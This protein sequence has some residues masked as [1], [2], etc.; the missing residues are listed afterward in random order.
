M[1]VSSLVA[2]AAPADAAVPAN[3]L[4][5]N[6]TP[7]GPGFEE[8]VDATDATHDADDLA[9]EEACRGEPNPFPHLL[10]FAD[11]IWYS[12]SAEDSGTNSVDTTGEFSGPISFV[13]IQTPDGFECVAF[14]GGEVVFEAIAG[15]TYTVAVIDFDPTGFPLSVKFNAAVP[16]SLVV[17]V[18]DRGGYYID[19]PAEITGTYTCNS[20]LSSLQLNVLVLQRVGKREIAGFE[21][22]SERDDPIC[23]ESP[24]PWVA[25]VHPVNGWYR[26]GQAEVTVDINDCSPRNCNEDPVGTK[27]VQLSRLGT[28]GPTPPELEIDDEPVLPPIN[29]PMTNDTR[30]T[31]YALTASQPVIVDTR[32]ATTASE[33]DALEDECIY[34]IGGPPDPP[35]PYL[36]K[37][38]WFTFTAPRDETIWWVNTI[39]SDYL[40]FLVSRPLPGSVAPELEHASCGVLEGPLIAPTGVPVTIMVT[41]YFGP[42]DGDGGELQIVVQD[43][44]PQAFGTKVS[45]DPVA[46]FDK[47][48]V[49]TVTGTYTC[50]EPFP[51]AVTRIT[52]V[53]Q[54]HQN[55]GRFREGM[56][57]QIF[58][59][60]VDCDGTVGTWSIE[61]D[62]RPF[63]IVYRGGPAYVFVHAITRAP[64]MAAEGN[65]A[66]AFVQLKGGP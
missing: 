60:D 12:F 16:F 44:P 49:A 50:F 55:I 52:L 45:I 26:G 13:A 20:P 32:A 7:V 43:H 39:G 18:D 30:A 58:N 65:D 59:T 62:G 48:G 24:H 54:L 47:T 10:Q 25:L 66:D 40:P 61:M 37:S 57:N 41:D 63:D 46:T 4:L 23:D 21:T 29:I 11:T 53:V 42:E 22:T 36:R 56:L 35:L 3:D 8:L 19:G 51:D 28:G 15:Q 5:V 34:G 17:T 27:L 9:I 1:V 2:V 31:A 6:A 33:D 64:P 14:G 38:V